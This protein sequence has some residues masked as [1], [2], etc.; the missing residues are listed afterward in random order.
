MKLEFDTGLADNQFDNLRLSTGQRKRLAM[1]VAQLEDKPV[2]VFDEWAAE[3]SPNFRVFFYD[4]LLP[5]LKARGKTVIAITHDN[6]F[7]DR[8][9]HLYRLR[10]GQLFKAEA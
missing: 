4:T 6:A 8:A 9:D 5:E 2:Y 1:I 7:F 3:Q 10:E